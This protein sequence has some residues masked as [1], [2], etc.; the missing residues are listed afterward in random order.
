MMQAR[1]SLAVGFECEAQSGRRSHVDGSGFIVVIVVERNFVI[2]LVIEESAERE[3]E[4]AVVEGF[5]V[6]ELVAEG[7][8]SIAVAVS[9]LIRIDRIEI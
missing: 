1:F 8:V 3:F 5:A 2:C 7:I 9:Q 4:E 6:N